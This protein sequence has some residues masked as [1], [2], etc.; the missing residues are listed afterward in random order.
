MFLL[1]FKE[2]E[3]NVLYTAEC[4]PKGDSW[5]SVTADFSVRVGIITDDSWS[6]VLMILTLNI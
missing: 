5:G 6:V 3:T 2:M 1:F 4:N